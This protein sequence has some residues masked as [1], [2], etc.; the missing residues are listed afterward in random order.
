MAL[1]ADL[2][3][4][5]RLALSPIRGNTHAERLESFY[6]SQADNYDSFRERLL[7]GRRELFD[8]L[9][10]PEGAVWVD[11]GGGTGASLEFW[12]DKLDRISSGYI[13]DLSPSLLNVARKR[14]GSLGLSNIKAVEADVTAFTPEEGQ[15]DVVTFSYS[16]TMIPNWFAAI[17]HAIRILKPG[18][19]IGVVDFFVA[20]KHASVDET[21][22][23]WFTR[24]FWPAWFAQD[25]VFLSPDHVAYLENAFETVSFSAHRAKVPY[26]PLFRVPYYRF[27]GKKPPPA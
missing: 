3:I 12:L 2:K 1:F 10:L 5:Y 20:R 23:G 18:G 16:L 22:H 25:N 19:L 15:A 26:M 14:A 27:I 13:V 6:A 8:E 11:M 21:Q 24:T 7:R 17:D 9:D 4:L